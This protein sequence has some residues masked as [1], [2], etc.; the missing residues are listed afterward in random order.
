MTQS[1]LGPARHMAEGGRSTDSGD[2]HFPPFPGSLKDRVAGAKRR[3]CA[4][5][6]ESPMNDQAEHFLTTA[7]TKAFGQRDEA[8]WDAAAGYSLNRARIRKLYDYYRDTYLAN[9]DAFLWA[10]L[11]R[12]AGGVV[13]SGLDL[14]IDLPSA[15]DPNEVTI[16]FVQIGKD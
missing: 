2:L 9:P 14:M 5:Q 7:Y 12:M 1:R 6:G 16:G 11:A 15:S 13:V 8:A 10:G 4:S 3:S